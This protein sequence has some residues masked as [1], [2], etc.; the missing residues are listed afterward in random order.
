MFENCSILSVDELS[1]SALVYGWIK[2][3]SVPEYFISH[4]WQ[5]RFIKLIDGVLSML[6]NAS[7]DTAVWLDIL[8]VNQHTDTCLDINNALHD[9]RDTLHRRYAC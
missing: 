3:A 9:L 1:T 8:A 6:R 2:D 7:D 4:A 5:G